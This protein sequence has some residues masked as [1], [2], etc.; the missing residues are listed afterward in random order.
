MVQTSSQY[1][2]EAPAHI[3]TD[4]Q[5]EAASHVKASLIREEN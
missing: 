3:E 2:F 1:Q 4:T 5:V